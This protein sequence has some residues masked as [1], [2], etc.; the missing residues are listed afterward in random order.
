MG[1]RYSFLLFQFRSE[2]NAH[3][4]TVVLLDEADVFL[5]QRS[6]VNLERNALVS[7]FLRVLEYYD[8][9]LILT[10]N[11]VGIF[12][13]AFRSRIQLSLRYKN[14]GQAERY[15]IWENFLKH[16]DQFQQTVQSGPKSQSQQVPLIGYGMDISDLRKHL[17]ELSQV[18]L[19]G[20]EI[21]NA[22]SIARQLALYRKEALQFHHLKDVMNE[23]KKF[24]DYLNELNDGFSADAICRD[25]RE[26]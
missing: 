3:A 24:D 18:E 23:A 7:V 16:L 13:E 6:L 25:R 11:R 22:L 5:E 17:S 1:L 21:R 14:L 19:N 4:I 15:Q 9:I 2:L 26:R 10:S 8:G 12:D 20:R